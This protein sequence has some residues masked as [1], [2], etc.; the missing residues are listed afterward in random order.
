MRKGNAAASSW[1]HRPTGSPI[2]R[3]S[4]SGAASEP[5]KAETPEGP[6]PTPGKEQGSPLDALASACAAEEKNSPPPL[7]P[8]L[9][10]PV[11]QAPK[12]GTKVKAEDISCTD[13][14]RLAIELCILRVEMFA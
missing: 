10:L 1:S 12:E 11:P 13:G 3:R 7:P 4:Y 14:K 2:C 5:P 9:P 6:S 8:I